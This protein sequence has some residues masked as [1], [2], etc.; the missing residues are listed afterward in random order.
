LIRP[1]SLEKIG[2][3]LGVSIAAALVNLLVA[4]VL[5]CGRAVP[6]GH[7]ANSKQPLADVWTSVGVVGGV[8][9]R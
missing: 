7:A 5:P 2:I 4:L 3:G 9:A 1:Q 6:I 8:W